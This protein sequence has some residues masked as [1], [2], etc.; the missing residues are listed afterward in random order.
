MG[1]W[2]RSVSE[3]ERCDAAH[4]GSSHPT[5]SEEIPRYLI[6][7]SNQ[8][9]PGI[10][11]DLAEFGIYCAD[12]ITDKAINKK[13]RVES[14]HLFTQLWRHHESIQHTG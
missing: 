8:I 10:R 14:R 5:F 11:G 4:C 9:R 12:D 6:V 7:L 2:K 3:S 13:R 1:W